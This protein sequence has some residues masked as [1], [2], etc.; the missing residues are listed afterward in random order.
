[1]FRSNAFTGP[2]EGKQ[3]AFRARTKCSRIVRLARR[4]ALSCGLLCYP[5][6]AP[7]PGAS[8]QRAAV[9]VDAVPVDAVP[10]DGGRRLYVHDFS[11]RRAVARSVRRELVH[12]LFEVEDVKLI[13]RDLVARESQALG[14][15]ATEL[16]HA[17]RLRLSGRLNLSAWIEGGVRRTRGKWIAKLQLHDGRSGQVVARLRW[18]HR[19]R[20]GLIRKI[21]QTLLPTLRPRLNALAPPPVPLAIGE[22]PSTPPAYNLLA[23]TVSTTAGAPEASR[24]RKSMKLQARREAA[25]AARVWPRHYLAATLNIPSRALRYNRT[26]YPTLANHDL[27]FPAL[28]WLDAMWFPWRQPSKRSADAL[29]WLGGMAE[30]HAAMPVS[31]SDP[32]GQPYRAQNMGAA[33]GPVAELRLRAHRLHL[34]LAYDIQWLGIHYEQDTDTPAYPSATYQSFRPTAGANLQLL[35]FVSMKLQLHYLSVLGTGQVTAQDWLDGSAASGMQANAHLGIRLTRT[36]DLL[37]GYRIRHYA[38]GD[39]QPVNPL[40]TTTATDQHTA[41]FAGLQWIA[42]H[43]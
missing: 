29:G 43:P 26:T 5:C 16:D 19:Y 39:S 31:D 33:L 7:I 27:R 8:A 42:G 12:K 30:V 36:F 25:E 10:F 34:G 20:L 4:I 37:V 3:N 11:G 21:K 32:F 24:R 22:Q 6:L 18:R 9:P 23:T 1:M 38:F 41:F 15:E 40:R 28:L 35:S 2:M 13:N 14:L 17:D